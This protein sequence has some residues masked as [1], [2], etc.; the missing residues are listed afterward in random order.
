MHLAGVL[1]VIDAIVR[2]LP[3]EAARHSEVI[4]HIG[5]DAIRFTIGIATSTDRVC[6]P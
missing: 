3:T 4:F 6:P 1:P 2:A 5:R